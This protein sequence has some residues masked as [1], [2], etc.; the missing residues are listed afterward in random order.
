MLKQVK[1]LNFYFDMWFIS[2]YTLAEG[3]QLISKMKREIS[4][5]MIIFKFQKSLVLTP[6]SLILS[7]AC[8]Y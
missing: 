6:F 1:S 8:G 4:K 5:A 2:I 7:F 3:H